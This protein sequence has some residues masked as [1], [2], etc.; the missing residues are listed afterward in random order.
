MLD[1]FVRFLFHY[2]NILWNNFLGDITANNSVFEFD[3][4]Y[5]LQQI[6]VTSTSNFRLSD[7]R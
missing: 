5:Y 7:L 4:A 3:Q 6:K 1:I 2:S